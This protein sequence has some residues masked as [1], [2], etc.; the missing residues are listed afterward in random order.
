M[1]STKRTLAQ[2]CGLKRDLTAR[3][4]IK[5]AY[6]LLSLA[7]VCIFVEAGIVLAVASCLNFVVSVIHLKS[8]DIDS[9]ID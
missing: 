1:K 7:A 5:S 4:I 8:V 3:E 6:F 9:I 2:M